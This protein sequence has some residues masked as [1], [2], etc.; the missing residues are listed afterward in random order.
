M[1]RYL[2]REANIECEVI[3]GHLS[4]CSSSNQACN[5]T[6]NDS[7]WWNA[8]HV[9]NSGWHLLDAYCAA[10]VV[11]ELK[12][13][14]QYGYYQE[15]VE[16]FFLPKPHDFIS[17]HF[18]RDS[19]WQLLAEPWTLAQFRSQVLV[20]A[21]FK[22][23]LRIVTHGQKVKCA[24]NG[25]VSI[26]L[27]CSANKVD[28]IEFDFSF[29]YLD[30]CTQFK[31]WDL[32]MFGR[33]HMEKNMAVFTIRPP[34]KGTYRL[35]LASS[36]RD[37]S[38]GASHQL[39]VIC[40]Y[41]IHCE[42]SP[43]YP[44]PWPYRDL[45]TKTWGAN[46][47]AANFDLSPQHEGVAFTIDDAPLELRFCMGRPLRF[48][49][50]LCEAGSSKAF[51]NS[52]LCR[53]V[54]NNACVFLVAAPAAGEYSLTIYATDPVQDDDN[55]YL[56]YQYLVTCT[57]RPK[58]PDLFPVLP[59][60][61]L[62]PQPAAC[63]CQLSPRSHKDPYINLDRCDLQLSFNTPLRLNLTTKL[64]A[65]D[66]TQSSKTLQGRTLCQIRS[67]ILSFSL[68]FPKPGIYKFEGYALPADEPS[69]KLPNVFNYLIHCRHH[70]SDHKFPVQ[71]PNK[72][73]HPY[74]LHEPLNGMLKPCAEQVAGTRYVQYRQR[75]KIEVPRVYQ[76][77]VVWQGDWTQL[78]ELHPGIWE[79]ELAMKKY[80]GGQGKVVVW[81]CKD[82]QSKGE[83]LL[84][85]VIED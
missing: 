81:T 24:S 37:A 69:E 29:T 21:I 57:Q 25:T 43:Q 63:K 19:R 85:Y 76:V 8:V 36:D 38:S 67:N 13:T 66:G 46:I 71:L 47:R 84:Q 49:A 35:K 11:R 79:G 44:M 54:N 40:E 59:A 41:E 17:T 53:V 22:H 48:L 60:D 2:C 70:G 45:R 56:V 58:M 26:L 78:D 39:G 18:P 34:E 82:K 74:Y 64:V 50:Y 77:G 10:D 15:A 20:K 32:N 5:N 65:C 33:H 75:F 30:G 6:D 9:R 83:P 62:S 28:S 42:T 1:T 14:D 7:H 23:G 61:Y 3:Q 27:E 12:A 72:G 16:Q 4:T 51:R 73:R 68:R 55:Y 52:V 31:G 80:P